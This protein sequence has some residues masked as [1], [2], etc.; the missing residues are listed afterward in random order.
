MFDIFGISNLATIIQMVSLA[1][2][3]VCGVAVFLYF[4]K[5]PRGSRE[6]NRF[7]SELPPHR[8]RRETEQ[9]ER[10]PPL[11]ASNAMEQ[12]MEPVIPIY[13]PESLYRQVVQSSVQYSNRR[14]ARPTAKPMSEQEGV[15]YKPKTK[16]P[17]LK[18]DLVRRVEE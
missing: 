15:V 9:F 11:R 2:A 8:R 5:R 10:E 13:I 3:V 12:P 6:T 16:R 4:A 17:P 7:E 1:V 18:E 14:S